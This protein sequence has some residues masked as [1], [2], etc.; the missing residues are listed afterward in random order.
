MFRP[1]MTI[2]LLATA[3]Y[4]LPDSAEAIVPLVPS[5]VSGVDK[6][7]NPGDC[8]I[9]DGDDFDDLGSTTPA[10]RC[11]A[12]VDRLADWHEDDKREAALLFAREASGLDSKDCLIVSDHIV[13]MLQRKN[14]W[15]METYKYLIEFLGVVVRG[16]SKAEDQKRIIGEIFGVIRRFSWTTP[17][18]PQNKLLGEIIDEILIPVVSTWNSELLFVFADALIDEMMMRVESALAAESGLYWNVY[19]GPLNLIFERLPKD[20]VDAIRSSVRWRELTA[21]GE[22]GLSDTL[23][24]YDRLLE[25]DGEKSGR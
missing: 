6:F 10:A 11:C 2:P 23:V 25:R 12:C 16:V 5:F 21:L 3:R 14:K 24:A 22:L 8:F 15:R 1:I 19:R 9:S 18:Y 20:N 4:A 17:G 13:G 7:R